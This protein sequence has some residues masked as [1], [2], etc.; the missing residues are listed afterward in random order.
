MQI[1]RF[2]DTVRSTN[3]LHREVGCERLIHDHVRNV[4][5]IQTVSM[6]L[7]VHDH[8]TRLGVVKPLES[9]LHVVAPKGSEL[10][11][12]LVQGRLNGQYTFLVHSKHDDVVIARFV[13]NVDDQFQQHVVLFG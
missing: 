7:R 5:Q 6:Q 4:D 1:A 3:E 10:N 13:M 2:P 11:H 8:H 12:T 9:G